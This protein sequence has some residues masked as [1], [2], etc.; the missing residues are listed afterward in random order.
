MTVHMITFALYFAWSILAVNHALRGLRANN[1]E[2]AFLTAIISMTAF[3][4]LLSD[5]VEK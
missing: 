2:V 5:I 3:F 1:W 4:E